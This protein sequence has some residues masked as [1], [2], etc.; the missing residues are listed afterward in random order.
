MACYDCEDCPRSVD[1]GG[2]CNQF[3]SDCPFVIVENYNSDELNSIKKAI[4]KI[5]VAVKKLKELDTKEYLGNEVNG[6]LFYI[7]NLEDF[8]S[9]DT[10]KEWEK[11]R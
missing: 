11:I 3:E 10:K 1:Y 6:I 8:V 4:K 9:E 7:S 5:S 2:K